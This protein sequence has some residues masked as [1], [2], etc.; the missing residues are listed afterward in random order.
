MVADFRMGL[1]VTSIKI[2]GGIYDDC[3]I[4]AG[5]SGDV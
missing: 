2:S 3:Y 4:M 5:E 1:A